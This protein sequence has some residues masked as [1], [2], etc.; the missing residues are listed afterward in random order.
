MLQA[1][2]SFFLGSFFPLALA[3]V[4]IVVDYKLSPQGAN[5]LL[6]VATA[7]IAWGVY[8]AIP[9]THDPWPKLMG[10]CLVSGIA[11][12][13]FYASPLWSQADSQTPMAPYVSLVSRYTMGALP[14]VVPARGTVFVLQ[15]APGVSTWLT[16][17]TNNEGVS[18]PWPHA[19]FL[20]KSTETVYV[21]EF[22]NHSDKTIVGL[23]LRLAVAFFEPVS[24]PVSSVP[25]PDGRV[26]YT[27]NLG[28]IDSSKIPSTTPPRELRR[29]ALV[30]LEDGVATGIVPGKTLY[31]LT[32]TFTIQAI[33]A[34]QTAYVY[35]VN[36]SAFVAGFN[37]P[38]EAEGHVDGKRVKVQIIRPEVTAFDVLPA[39]LMSPTMVNW[40]IADFSD[41]RN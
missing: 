15:L 30:R 5:W 24:V 16:S 33:P 14:V 31:S 38:V 7:L 25:L 6:M 9:G 12:L 40:G 10:A 11:G 39:Y 23:T 17:V 34:G 13:S 20:P 4:L 35:A 28:D 21:G 18:R 32:R 37:V 2:E 1:V 19:R 3:L 41:N 36:L 26:N 22:A 8:R 27:I 29:A